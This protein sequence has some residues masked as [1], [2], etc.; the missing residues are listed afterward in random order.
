M[1]TL[2]S[3]MQMKQQ[4][5]PESQII[6]TLQQQGIS[7][8]EIN[9]ALSQSKIKSELGAT[10]EQPTPNAPAPTMPAQPKIPEQPSQIPQT[11]TQEISTPTQEMQ[12][13]IMQQAPAPETYQMPAPAEMPYYEEYQPSQPADLE[14]INDIAEQI[15]EEK[16]SNLKKQ[17]TNLSRFKEELSLEVEK[18]NERLAK[19]EDVFNQ[20]QIAILGKIGEY[21]KDIQNIAKEMHET[22]NSFSK[23][24]N[25]LTENIKALQK[26][27]KTK[28]SAKTKKSSNDF[29]DYLR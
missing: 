27:T 13:S 22:Q 4:G 10:T 20:L 14:T 26:I 16:T 15:V 28:S 18:I 5:I 17:I 24:I 9:E 21:G 19:I 7:P 1:A 11:F 29:E 6:Q 23:I 3:V 12:P 25:P 2:E 8:K